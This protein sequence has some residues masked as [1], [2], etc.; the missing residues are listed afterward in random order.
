M[1]S[2]IRLREVTKSFGAASG[3]AVDN[4]S[5]DIEAGSIMALVGPSGCGKTTTL[6]MINRKY[7]G[8]VMITHLVSLCMM[9]IM[10]LMTR[11]TLVGNSL[12]KKLPLPSLANQTAGG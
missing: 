7:H 4:L 8:K 10:Q 6:R 9:Y 3:A 5:L 12:L 2:A 1:S 11:I